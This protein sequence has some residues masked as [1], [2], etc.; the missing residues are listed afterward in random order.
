MC[1]GINAVKLGLVLHECI[2]TASITAK[3]SNGRKWQFVT[4]GLVKVTQWHFPVQCAR[5][6]SVEKASSG[7]KKLGPE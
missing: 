2:C 3:M 1:S 4:E 7:S 5:W 6:C